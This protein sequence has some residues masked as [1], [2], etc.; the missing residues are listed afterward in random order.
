VPLAGTSVDREAC[1][2]EPALLRVPPVTDP[3][4]EAQFRLSPAESAVV[5]NRLA[6][7]DGL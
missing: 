2:D 4:D 3:F 7:E 1:E 6:N 5:T